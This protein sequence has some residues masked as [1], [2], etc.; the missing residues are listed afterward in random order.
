MKNEEI[1]NQL[2]EENI[3]SMFVYKPEN[4]KYISDFY[5]SSFA[6]LI[7]GEEPVLYVNSIDKIDA[8]EQSTIETRDIRKLGELKDLLN[9]TIAVES[10]LDFE[11]LKFLTD[12]T[13]LLK[14]STVLE[15]QRKTKTKE[16]ITKIRNSIGIASNAIKEID[17]TSTEKY[18]AASLEFDMTINGSIKPAFDTIVASGNRSSSPHSETSM[19]RVETPIVV[20]WGA[21]YDHYCSDITRTFVDSERQEEIWNIVLEA[22]KAAINTISP[23][24][25]LADVDKAARD[26]ITEY[27][28]GEYFIHSTGHGFGLDIHENPNLSFNAEGVLEE[29]MI[30][31]AEPGIYIPGE[32]GVRIEDDVL[33]KK[34][35]EVLTKNL[36][37]KLEFNL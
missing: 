23:G 4:I 25:K 30:V 15:D 8:E 35:N 34:N 6:Y 14:L 11:F 36:D 29:N 33:V 10:S 17:F 18:A 37:K 27:G 19:N 9:G 13:N 12:D 31:T 2:K 32:F 16:E 24:V 26:V 22:Q 28:Y 7:I 21:K 1:L 20:D 3:D 5:P